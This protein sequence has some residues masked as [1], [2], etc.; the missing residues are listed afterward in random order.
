MSGD[1]DIHHLSAAYALDALDERER[2]AFEAHYPSCEVCRGDVQAFRATLAQVAA[3]Q[4]A[5]QSAQDIVAAFQRGDALPESPLSR[6]QLT[7]VADTV[8][9]PRREMS[10]AE[11]VGAMSN[12]SAGNLAAGVYL[13]TIQVG[14]QT[15]VQK[16]TRL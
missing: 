8:L 1:I 9:Q 7:A 5:G 13:V 4:A 12:R 11:L 3:A 2:V 6:E 15:L 10:Q 14:S 16:I